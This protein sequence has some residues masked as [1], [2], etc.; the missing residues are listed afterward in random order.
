MTLDEVRRIIYGKPEG[1][2]PAKYLY[3][4]IL[5][6]YENT[7]RIYLKS[8]L[9]LALFLSRKNEQKQALNLLDA[10]LGCLKIPAIF[11]T[12]NLRR[13]FAKTIYGYELVLA[14]LYEQN[15]LEQLDEFD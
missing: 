4:T 1:L 15:I 12:V 14:E 6:L 9:S 3:A 10:K 11:T 7:K 8:I 5:N 2:K 13:K